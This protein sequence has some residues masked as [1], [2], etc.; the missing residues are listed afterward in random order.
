MGMADAKITRIAPGLRMSQGVIYAG[1]LY[2]AGQ[3]DAELPDVSGQTKNVLA[4]IDALL[5][6]AGSC[7]SRVLSASIWLSDIS[8][9]D[10]MN[11]VWEKWIDPQQ[12]PA[13]ATVEGNLA[14]PDYKVE[15]AVIAVAG[16]EV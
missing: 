9:F 2:T 4:K 15:I 12:P 3:V 13:R 7:K 5:S 6:Q 16:H 8:T 11:G 14:A 10:E 1:L